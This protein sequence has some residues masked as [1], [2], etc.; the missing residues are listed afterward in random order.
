M[1]KIRMQLQNRKPIEQRIGAIQ[2]AKNILK[3]GLPAIYQGVTPTVRRKKSNEFFFHFNSQKNFQQLLRDVTFSLL[4]FP[5]YSN[6]K[7]GLAGRA[8][9]HPVWGLFRRENSD[10]VRW[11]FV[12]LLL[13]L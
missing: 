8:S 10:H 4:Y 12:L 11:L 1:Y 6:M 13:H 5:M 3:G 7:L 2:V 9:D